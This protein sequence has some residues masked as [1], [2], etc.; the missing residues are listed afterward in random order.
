MIADLTDTIARISDFGRPK[1]V[2]IRV[3]RFETL[4]DA[5]YRAGVTLV[6]AKPSE[7]IEGATFMGV[8]VIVNPFLP[9][10]FAAVVQDG[11]VVNIL[12]LRA[13]EDSA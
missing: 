1:K 12:D 8:P 9:T 13:K 10:G 5:A 4:T 3:D 11:E 2:E 7:R 6:K